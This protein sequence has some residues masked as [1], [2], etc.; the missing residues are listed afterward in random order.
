MKLQTIE[1]ET[2]RLMDRLRQA[3]YDLTTH[4]EEILLTDTLPII[5]LAL[6]T[7]IGIKTT[8]LLDRTEQGCINGN[9]LWRGNTGGYCK[10]ATA[11]WDPSHLS[12]RNDFTINV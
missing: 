1:A 4:R 3:V 5:G 12:Y 8:D 7:S 6:V 10:H 11:L 9:T 2:D